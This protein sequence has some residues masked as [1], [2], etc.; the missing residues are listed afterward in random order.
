MTQKLFCITLILFLFCGCATVY[1][2]ATQKRELVFI[3]TPN[4]ISLG[5]MID[6]S[7][8]QDYRISSDPRLNQRV[9]YIGKSIAA[10][11]DRKDL[12]YRF[13][14]VEDQELNAFSIPGGYV[15]VNTGLLKKANDE[16]LAGVMAHEIGHVVAR[17]AVKRLQSVLGFNIVLS[18]AFNKSNA[19]EL[20]NA[21]NVIYNLVSLGYSREDERQADKLAVIYTVRAGYDP[22]GLISFFN[23]ISEEEKKHGTG[24]IPVFLRSHPSVNERIGNIRKEIKLAGEGG[25][26]PGKVLPPSKPALFNGPPA[27]P[28][29][30]TRKSCPICKRAFPANVD[31]CPYDGARLK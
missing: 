23:K 10:V 28:K 7:I 18:I 9:N 30:A 29:A 3:S 26:Y 19:A 5:K 16:E 6:R 14:V 2:P 11:C 13:F 20:Y 31:Y 25:D 27:Q 8:R 22:R 15:Y 21:V 12:E 4:E 17:H 1:N 24:N